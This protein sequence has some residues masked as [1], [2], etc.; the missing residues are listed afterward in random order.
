MKEESMLVTMRPT[1][2]SDSPAVPSRS[3]REPGNGNGSH[4]SKKEEPG[5]IPALA[6]S[7]DN[8]YGCLELINE[9][10]PAPLMRIMKDLERD[11]I[12]QAMTMARAN[13]R[14]AAVLLGI[15]YTTLYAKIKKHGLHFSKA[16]RFDTDGQD[17]DI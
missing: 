11:I 7:L 1:R 9:G 8:L 10:R 16:V 2:G 17:F 4:F 3:A 13:M 15:K 14:K 12:S 6:F 5:A